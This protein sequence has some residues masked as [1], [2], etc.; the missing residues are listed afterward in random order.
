MGR[1]W[2]FSSQTHLHHHTLHSVCPR[3]TSLIRICA[4][5]PARS[6]Q[7]HKTIPTGHDRNHIRLTTSTFNNPRIHLVIML[8]AHHFVFFALEA[9][10]PPSIRNPPRSII[11]IQTIHKC[12]QTPPIRGNDV[13]RYSTIRGHNHKFQIWNYRQYHLPIF[14]SL[15]CTICS[16]LPF[17]RPAQCPTLQCRTMVRKV[18]RDVQRVEQ[19]KHY[20]CKIAENCQY[21]KANLT[22]SITCQQLFGS[23]IA[24]HALIVLSISSRKAK[25]TTKDTSQFCNMHIRESTIL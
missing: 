18:A 19:I 17:N 20:Q 1:L 8:S 12:I 24:Q 14:N 4:E 5:L 21:Q 11:H 23:C 10:V 15:P 6:C 13:Q 22:P 2:F 9:S 7:G 16:Y 3:G 25:G